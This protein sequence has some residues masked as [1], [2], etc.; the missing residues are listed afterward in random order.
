MYLSRW[1]QTDVAVKVLSK[2][3]QNLS[4]QSDVVPQDPSTWKAWWETSG[5]GPEVLQHVPA[6]ASSVSNGS[7]VNN[8]TLLHVVHA[9]LAANA[10][11]L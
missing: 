2:V 9:H 10:A 1:Q 7:S 6:D 11:S 8:R 4:P 3:M 5:R